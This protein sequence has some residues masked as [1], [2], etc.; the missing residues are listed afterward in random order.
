M[1]TIPRILSFFLLITLLLMDASFLNAQ[2]KKDQEL[3][4]M[5]FRER[6]YEKAAALYQ[7][8]YDQNPTQY[9]YTYLLFSQLEIAEYREAEKLVRKHLKK[10]NN[11]AR[12]KVDLGFV[13]IRQG[14]AN[15]AEK[16]FREALEETDP[17]RPSISALANAFLSRQQNE[18]ALEAYKKG[19]QMNKGYAFRT[20][21]A[22]IYERMGKFPELLEEY[23]LMLEEDANNLNTVQNKMQSVLATD[24]EGERN[25]TFRQELLRKVQREPGKLQFAELLLWHS[26]QQK[27][28]SLAL[29]Q[30][31]SL[32]KRLGEDGER[33]YELAGLAAANQDYNAAIAA[34]DYVIAKGDASPY[35]M[36][37]TILHLNVR[38]DQVMQHYNFDQ[39]ALLALEQE[40]IDLIREFGY[41]TPSLPLITD[42][43]RLQAFY[44]DKPE[45]AIEEL[46]KA[47][48][49]YG[50]NPATEAEIKIELGD[51]YLFTGEVWEAT[52]LYSQVDKAFKNDAVG[53]LARYKNARLS[54]YIGEFDWAKAQLNVLK[55]ATSKLIA[56]DAMHLSLLINDNQED[57]STQLALSAFASA[58]LLLYRNK[59][60]SAL[61]VLNRIEESHSYHPIFD[62]V[63]MKKAEVFTRLRNYETVDSLYARVNE[64]YADGI[65]GDDALYQRALLAEE[66]FSDQDKAMKLY[67]Q[68]LFEYP[69][70]LFT[71]DARKR[72]RRLRGDFIN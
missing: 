55:A 58:D 54:F 22:Q 70:S 34:L 50:L 41:N 3:A 40:H 39:K 29:V 49:I 23:L 25:E 35:Y 56:N 42:L 5:F 46:E 37:A 27:E 65:Y 31:R 63:L 14:D 18:Y 57:D 2:D 72:F 12:Y 69:G 43:A 6:N 68:L 33:V 26:V 9:F 16:Y 15:K 47:R 32:D 61:R 59:V 45:Q 24:P 52:L 20:E 60:D 21:M 1:K 66:V 7:K 36:L 10:N 38:F 48:A 71:V 30:A 8:L 4:M 64:L 51:I 28:F 53:H 62:D 44:L 11:Q 13:F 67:E 19:R 17:S